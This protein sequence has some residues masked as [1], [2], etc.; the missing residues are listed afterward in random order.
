[1]KS[2]IKKAF[3]LIELLVV[4]SVIALL[5]AL[6]MPA[7]GMAR[8]Q[9]QRAVCQSNLRQQHTACCMYIDDFEG[10]FPNTE[11]LTATWYYLWGG[12]QGS[13]AGA[14]SSVRLLN[15]YV[16]LEGQVNTKSENK[17]LYAFKCPAD[18]GQIEGNWALPSTGRDSCWDSMGS[19]YLP[20]FSANNNDPDKGLWK[21]KI[22][23]VK[24]AHDLILVRDDSFNAF[25]ISPEGS[26]GGEPFGY[27]YWHNT[28][29]NGWGNVTFVDGHCE[30]LQGT[31]NNPDFQNGHGWTFLMNK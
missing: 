31:Q 28:K 16:C 25:F 22:T 30:Y 7:L 1:M 29:E 24:N 13:E 5:L 11:Y 15:P 10:Y 21:K 23:Q 2:V 12:K 4:I 6:L 8:K 26:Y 17:Q 20:N 19:S 9:A 27:F 14:Q 18:K 3:T